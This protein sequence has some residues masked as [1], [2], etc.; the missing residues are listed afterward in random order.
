VEKYGEELQVAAET[1]KK[2]W[3]VGHVV[4][5]RAMMTMVVMC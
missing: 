4:L 5:Q 1:L 3:Q 2:V